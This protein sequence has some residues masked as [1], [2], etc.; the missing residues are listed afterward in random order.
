MTFWGGSTTVS[1]S[2]PSPTTRDDAEK[3]VE[4]EQQQK[5]KQNATG[6]TL[7]SMKRSTFWLILGIAS[8]AVIGISVGGAVGGTIS[9]R[10]NNTQARVES[11][12]SSSSTDPGST[13]PTKL[14]QPQPTSDCPGSNG[15]TYNS[16]YLAGGHGSVP[17][18]AGLRFVKICSAGHPGDNVGSGFF[19]TFDE[20]IE[21]CASL[22]YWAANKGCKT[23][24]YEATGTFPTNCWA[25]NTT[26]VR[27]FSAIHDSVVLVE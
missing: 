3:E 19:R 8:L 17:P 5:Q 24:D 10:N 20:C 11:P 6:G 26:R 27:V 2:H 4:A 7:A 1:H 16:A 12:T 13:T 22:N 21:L 18:G 15:T 9:V 14:P 23:V 25:H